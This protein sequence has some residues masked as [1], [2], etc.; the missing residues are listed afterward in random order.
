M[1]AS[2]LYFKELGW[3]QPLVQPAA[4][5]V[6]T[7][8]SHGRKRDVIPVTSCSPTVS[9]QQDVLKGTKTGGGGRELSVLVG[10]IRGCARLPS[11]IGQT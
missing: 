5:A 4:K 3:T 1:S 6:Q 2:P 9:R 8:Y 7:L 11:D 10:E